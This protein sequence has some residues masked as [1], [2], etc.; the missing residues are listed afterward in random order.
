[1]LNQRH[2]DQVPNQLLEPSQE[3]D[4]E[5]EELRMLPQ[6]QLIQLE[7]VVVEEVEDSEFLSCCITIIDKAHHKFLFVIKFTSRCE[8]DDFREKSAFVSIYQRKT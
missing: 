3:M 8:F 5:S 2:Q 4:S 6:S 7:E 1:M